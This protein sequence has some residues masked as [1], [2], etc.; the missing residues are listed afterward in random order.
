M[1]T[2]TKK[3]LIELGKSFL[4]TL[5]GVLILL[6][7]LGMLSPLV[8]SWVKYEV[9]LWNKINSNDKIEQPCP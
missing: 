9:W 1:T 8:F 6:I 2:E 4:K 7:V 5:K 3:A